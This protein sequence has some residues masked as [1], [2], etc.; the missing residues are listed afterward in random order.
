MIPLPRNSA[1]IAA[2]RWRMRVRFHLQV[3]EERLLS[4]LQ[5]VDVRGGRIDLTGKRTEKWSEFVVPVEA[6]GTG[7]T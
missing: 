6:A 3:H 1:P 2:P 5:C 7:K 4:D